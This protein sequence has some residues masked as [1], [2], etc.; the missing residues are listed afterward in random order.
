MKIVLKPARAKPRTEVQQSETLRGLKLP[1]MFKFL[2]DFL[3]GNCLAC[4]CLNKN[5]YIKAL[6]V[7]SKKEQTF[8]K[9][10][11]Q[12]PLFVL[13]TGWRSLLLLQHKDNIENTEED[14]ETA[15]T[16]HQDVAELVLQEGPQRKTGKEADG[17]EAVQYGEPP[18]P[19]VRVG[20]GDVHHEGV[21]GQVE[22]GA[23]T[24]QVLQALQQ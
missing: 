6:I 11:C 23:S 19:G 3:E 5:R 18:G 9:F 1:G 21:G 8:I 14:S 4:Q 16:E 22:G 13:L 17:Y 7:R 2:S 10:D 24:S 12:L 20:V 15:H